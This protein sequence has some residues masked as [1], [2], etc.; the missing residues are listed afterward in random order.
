VARG[1]GGP[2]PLFYAYRCATALIAPFAY[3]KVARRLA[4]HGVAPARLAERQG[5]ATLPRPGGQLIWFHGASVG[6][7]LAAM[8]LIARM[9]ERLPE[10]E[11]LLTSGTAT[12]AE[13]AAKRMPPRCRHQFA[14]LDSGRAVARFLRHW[15]P[16]AGVFV[17]SE[18]WPV[19]LAAAAR[20]G[21]RLA[22]VNARLSE[23]SI[24][25]WQ[26]KAATARFVLGRFSLFLT[27]NEQMAES[28]IAMGAAP[29]RVQPGGNLKAAAPALPV[30]AAALAE[31]QAQLG[32]RP[33]WIASS[34]HPGEEEQVLAAHQA[35]LRQFPGLC[36]VLVPRHPERSGVIAQMIE[37]EG[38]RCSRRSSGG[39]I[40]ADTQVYLADTLGELGLWYSLSPVVFLG[41]SLNP[42]GGHNPFE[43][44]K[45]G[46][47]VITG[48][49]T[50]NFAETFPPM[51][52]CGGAVEIRDAAGLAD[53][54]RHWLETP[55][56][57][58]TA[59][60]VASAFAEQQCGALEAVMDRLID[61]LELTGP[62][63]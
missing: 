19:T 10:A 14:P 41:G 18:L 40:E 16:D 3:R 47:A 53:A 44:A 61:G 35:L 60:A 15:R 42:V 25:R 56:A 43:V 7:S 22:L 46:A 27:Q 11:F 54:V 51:I 58:E 6:E 34:T 45:A 39:S 52:A 23:R 33:V 55:A 37:A 5:R 1:P 12:S 57:L 31:V 2:T 26:K 38:L 9:G 20:R 24:A 49:G 30:E 8:T 62:A 59:R 13:M 63:A 36:L 48:P 17:E 50:H 21:T 28:L 29:E 32:G 4:A